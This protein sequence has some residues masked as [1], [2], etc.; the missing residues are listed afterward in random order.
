MHVCVWIYKG[1]QLEWG[2]KVTDAPV[3]RALANNSRC[4]NE[5]LLRGYEYQHAVASKSQAGLASKNSKK[6]RSWDQ[7][8]ARLGWILKRPR[9]LQIGQWRDQEIQASKPDTGETTGSQ[10]QQ[11]NLPA[12]VCV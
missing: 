9:D 4:Q 11:R 8:D 3:S 1:Q 5:C 2:P 10:D 6:L 7:A 12:H